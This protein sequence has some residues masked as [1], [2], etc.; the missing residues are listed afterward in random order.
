MPVLPAPA[1]RSE[2][3]PDLAEG[4]SDAELVAAVRS[5][6]VD[7]YG[8]LYRRHV[9]AART[10]ARQLT[11]CAAE[12]DDLVAEAFTKVFVVLRARGGPDTAFRAYLFTVLRHVRCD[13]ARQDHRVELSDDMSRHDEGVPWVDTAVGGVDAGLAG[14]AF[15]RLPERW[16]TV[17]WQTEVERRSPTEVA[18]RL[19]LTPNGVAALAYRAREGLRQAYL[20]EHL[21]AGGADRHRPTVDRLGAWARGALSPR[22]R[23]DVDAHLAACAPCRDL[24]VELTDVGGALC[25]VT[26]PRAG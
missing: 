11:G 22:L 17:L 15:T 14:R 16:R 9:R 5:G 25:R 20:Q 2:R 26:T 24:A 1:V 6:A 18:T 10:L 8:V 4:P 12:R 3:V 19:G 21:G 23:A 13:R 7:A